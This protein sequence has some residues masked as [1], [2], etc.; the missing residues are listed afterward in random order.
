[1]DLT[2]DDFLKRIDIQDVLMDAGYVFNRKDGIRY[3]SYVRPDSNGYHVKGDKFIV[4]PSRQTCFQPPEFKVYNVISFITSH[5]H[6]FRDYQ[7]GMDPYRLVNLVCNRLLNNPIDRTTHPIIKSYP[8][9]K[10]FNIKDYTLQN[11]Q[12]YN[13]DNIK[14]FYPY[15]VNRGININTQKAF[16]N[17]FMLATLHKE[18]G[19]YFKN[20]SFP[21]RIPGKTS[22]QPNDLKDIV[23]FEERGR[24]R[25]DGSSGYKGKARGSNSSEGLWIASP[26]NT[27]LKAAS[28]VLWFESAYDAMAYYQLNSKND[29]TLNN[30]VFLSTGGNPTVMQF[31]GVIN[32]ASK[33]THHLCFDNDLAG[34]QFVENF[35][36]ELKNVREKTADIN[37]QLV[38]YMQS[39]SNPDDKLSGIPEFLPEDLYKAY[40]AYEAA[41]EEWHSMKQCGSIHPDDL[42]F[43]A[44][45]AIELREEFKTKLLTAISQKADQPAFIREV[46]S[47]GSKDWNELLHKVNSEEAN[48]QEDSK[49]ETAG[50]DIDNDGNLSAE[51]CDERKKYSNFKR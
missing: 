14:Q 43:Q 40:G 27:E 48:N 2:F 8:M 49:N 44:D 7:D 17:H 51:E 11:F 24:A 45:K 39:L 1:M 21:L 50:L 37:P 36:T 6:L 5:P 9:M 23:G 47:D 19:T 41:E 18:N 25:L 4:H 26:N 16:A 12:K 30:S 42:K 32:E 33:A 46:P 28:K 34:N 20:L 13:F 15:F 22:S 10:D 29:N 31:R 35:K 38:D 3:P